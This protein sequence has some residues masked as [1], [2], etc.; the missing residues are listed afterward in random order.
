M[1][2]KNHTIGFEIDTSKRYVKRYF[3]II[4]ILVSSI[5]MTVFFTFNFHTSRTLERQLVDQAR[6]FF[7]EVVVTRRWVAIHGGVY[8][9][10]K[11]AGSVNPYLEK[12]EG[13]RA[14]IQCEG[15][16][17]TLKNP[18]LVTRE[19][20]EMEVHTGQLQYKIT[21]R[22]SLNPNNKPDAF[23]ARSLDEFQIGVKETKII[24]P[25]GATRY[26]RYMGPLIT[27]EPCLKCH[28]SQG[29]DVGDIRGGISVSI[30]AEEFIKN[31]NISRILMLITGTGLIALIIAL[32]HFL[33]HY[34]IRDLQKAHEQLRKMALYDAL[35]G[36]Y[37]RNSGLQLMQNEISRSSRQ[38]KP[39]SLAIIDLDHFK[40]IND[41]YGH[42]IGDVILKSFAS[43]IKQSTRQ[44]DISCRYG[45]EEFLLV[46]PDTGLDEARIVVHRIMEKIRSSTIEK[47]D[48]TISYT[49]SSGVV[50]NAIDEASDSLIGR[51]DRL[52]YNAKSQGRNRICS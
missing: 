34:F 39:L 15:E 21:S 44:H 36:L 29:Y 2:E 32:M 35:T 37:N 46:M 13:V 33:S 6:S 27:K 4:A 41:T 25:I 40:K 17:Y 11:I 3:G 23:E 9:P 12:I 50:T 52:L 14:T 19:L 42:Q 7:N 5:L 43:H 20:S 1:P 18:A 31:M 26:F 48:T 10:L 51:A 49:F 47:D 38:N 16:T 8:V 45:G 22:N 24:E 30:N 28:A